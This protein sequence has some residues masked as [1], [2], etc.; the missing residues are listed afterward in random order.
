VGSLRGRVLT[1]GVIGALIGAGALAATGV[2]SA[3]GAPRRARVEHLPAGFTDTLVATVQQPVAL[4]PTPDGRLLVAD[5][6]GFVRVIDA[7]GALLPNPALDLS[8]RVC[9]GGERGLLGL[10]VDPNFAT[11][12]FVYAYYTFNKFDKCRRDVVDVPE[13]RVSRFVMHGDTIDPASEKILVDGMK[14]YH[15]NHNGGDLGF[16]QD[17]FLYVSVGD[18]GCDY[19]VGPTACDPKNTIAQS[20]ETLEGKVLR[21]TRAGAIPKGNPFTGPGTVRCNVG[22][23]PAGERCREIYLYGF[24]NPF[25]FAF[26]P[27]A[28]GTRLFVDDTGEATWEEVDEAVSGANYGW[29]VREGPCKRASTTDCGPPPVG[30]TN[31]VFAYSHAATGC[32][33]ITGGAFVPDGLWGADYDGGYL[34][35]DYVCDRIFLLVPNGTGGWK[36]KVFARGLA[37]GGPIELRFAPHNGTP[38]LYYTTFTTNANQGQVRVIEPSAG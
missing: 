20:L 24:R 35:S 18:G 11:N 6:A 22:P 7:T 33:A 27:N 21:I 26:D 13:N 37:I 17:G 32:G 36:S 31:P 5:R 3:S 34:V 2:S 25:R 19:R 14:A 10:A 23:A 9:F 29:N 4:V 1:V 38:A 15:G 16:G 30:M 28:V 12:H 8:A